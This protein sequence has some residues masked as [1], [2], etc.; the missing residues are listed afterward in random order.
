LSIVSFKKN[1]CK[2]RLSYKNHN[3]FMNKTVVHY[4][5]F[6]VLCYFGMVNIPANVHAQTTTLEPTPLLLNDLSSFKPT[7]GN[8]QIAGEVVADRQKKETVNTRKGKDILVNI[9]SDKKRDNLF[10]TW[11]HGDIE[12][13]ID[14]MMPKG[15]NSGIYFQGRYEIQL[16]DSWGVQ[17]PKASD[18]GGIYERWDES[19]PDGRKGYEGHPPRYNVSRAPGLW[20]NFKI[21][22][23]APRFDQNGRKTANAK[24]VKVVHNGVVI[25]ENVE[26]SGPTRSGAFTDEKAMGPLMIQGDHG[27]VALRNIRYKMFDKSPLTLTNVR[28]NYYEGKFDK[29]PDFTTV[30]AKRT[31]NQEEGMSWTAGDAPNDF[32][33]QFTGNLQ[34]TEPGD[35]RFELV[36]TGASRLLIDNKTV[37]DH[38]NFHHRDEVADGKVKLA[39]GSHVVV[40][41]YSKNVSWLKPALGLFVEG[42]GIRRQAL[43]GVV[44]LPDPDPVGDIQVTAQM[45]L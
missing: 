25:H 11:E 23:Q 4:S 22:F 41:H 15:S 21:V 37:I 8:W 10:T 5:L 17:N 33:F 2:F 20:Q 45:N 27:P 9:P 31:G 44:S 12:L 6:L 14:F 3:F 13:D 28:Y 30:K 32:A 38:D 29:L 26:L 1:L 35:Y 18:C 16:F 34:I 36:S 42:P 7:A 40:V 24:F 39:V 19:K 43:H